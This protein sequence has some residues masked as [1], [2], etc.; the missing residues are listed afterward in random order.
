MILRSDMNLICFGVTLH[1]VFI[2]VCDDSVKSV[3]MD[4]IRANLDP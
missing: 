1:L 2:E 3:I 4:I